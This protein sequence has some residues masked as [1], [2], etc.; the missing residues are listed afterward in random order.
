MPALL[1]PGRD[2]QVLGP[3]EHPFP[4]RYAIRSPAL[5]IEPSIYLE[6]LVRDFVFFGGRI[7]IRKFDTPRDLMSLNE[8]IIVNCR[9]LGS[10]TL[11]NDEELVPVKG[12]LSVCVPELEVN[13]RHPA[14]CQT[15]RHQQVFIR[16]AAESSSAT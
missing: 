2:R 10:K 4:T 8:S 1:Q 6:T 11:F 3:G 15:A 13:Y 12:Q 9:G 16:E 5:T 14:V 7:L